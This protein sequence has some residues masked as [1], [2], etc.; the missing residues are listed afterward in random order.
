MGKG[1]VVELAYY[2]HSP[3]QIIFYLTL[4]G[5]D[6]MLVAMFDYLTYLLQALDY[7]P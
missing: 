3:S 7:D 5:L 6:E 2:V 1:I 4:S